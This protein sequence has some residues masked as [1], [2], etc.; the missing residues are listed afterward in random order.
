MGSGSQGL[1]SCLSPMDVGLLVFPV[2]ECR[3]KRGWAPTPDSWTCALTLPTHLATQVDTERKHCLTQPSGEHEEHRWPSPVPPLLLI[4]PGICLLV[5]RGTHNMWATA[6]VALLS[7]SRSSPHC[8]CHAPVVGTTPT[9]LW[10]SRLT[11]AA[12]P[13]PLMFPSLCGLR[14]ASVHTYTPRAESTATRKAVR[15]QI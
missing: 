4:R 3:Q 10:G 1:S 15:N 5:P 2:P 7:L 8:P 11:P 14:L 6:A 9:S 13:R 12:G